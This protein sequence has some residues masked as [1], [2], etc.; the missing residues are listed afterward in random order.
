[1]EDAFQTAWMLVETPNPLETTDSL[2]R[3][4]DWG[5]AGKTRTLT[6]REERVQ[7]ETIAILSA[8]LGQLESYS[9]S[10]ESPAGV[11]EA[12]IKTM[13][14]KSALLDSQRQVQQKQKELSEISQE[15]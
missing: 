14:L 9:R 4:R 7:G 5:P 10:G 2:Y 3:F 1:L 12:L 15:Q 8:D 6:V 13:G 11:R